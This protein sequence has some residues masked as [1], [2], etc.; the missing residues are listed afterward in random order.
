MSVDQWKN[1]MQRLGIGEHIEMYVTLK[2]KYAEKHRYYHTLEHIA[3]C[4]AL[5]DGNRQLARYPE[6]VELAIW[7]HDAVY[8]IFSSSNERDSASMAS[9]FLLDAGIDSTVV[10]RVSDL[11]MATSH[12]T[13]ISNS[14]Q[15]LIVDIDLS[16]LGC[17][18][19][20]YQKFE[21]AV[22]REYK[23]IPFFLFRRGRKKIL[24]S[25]LCREKIYSFPE[26][27]QRYEAQAR[28]N[29]TNAINTM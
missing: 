22:R 27:Y 2:E 1:L 15:S 24:N 8:N 26:F 11:I 20:A 28:E 18:P 9:G 3:C 13:Q 10:T 29:I 4:L 12:E 21:I 14:D 23:K 17:S 5:L 6:E 25:F 19:D 16:V 7:F